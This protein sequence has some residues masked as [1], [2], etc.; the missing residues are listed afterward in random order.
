MATYPTILFD[1]IGY[2]PLHSVPAPYYF[3][4]TSVH[5][6]PVEFPHA[7]LG[8]FSQLKAR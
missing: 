7:Y 1:P 5:N 4:I 6:G 3:T 2:M 8:T